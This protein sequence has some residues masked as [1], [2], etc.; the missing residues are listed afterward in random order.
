MRFIDEK[1]RL[2]GR[3]NIL[4]FLIIAAILVA[5]VWF[6][7]AKFGRDLGGDIASRE[8]NIEITIIVP[9]IR[10]TTV[11][12]IKNSSRM[13]EFKTGAYVGD[14]VEVSSEQA[15]IWLI[16]EDGR[17]IKTTSEN[18]VDA[19]VTI[20]GLARIGQ[21]VITMNGVEV[22]VGSSIGLKSQLAVFNG[23]IMSMDLDYEEA[24]H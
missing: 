6:G 5:L 4:D 18:K 23:H 20:R 15:E 2:F 9:G 13:F 8:K 17:W 21:D 10:P 12:A 16:Q 1:G 24:G 7:Y 14:V 11:E 22:R 19:Y 3:I